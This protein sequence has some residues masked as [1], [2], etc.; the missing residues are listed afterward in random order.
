MYFKRLFKSTIKS[1]FL[2]LHLNIKCFQVNED[3]DINE[4]DTDISVFVFCTYNALEILEIYSMN[5]YVVI[6]GIQLL[7]INNSDISYL[8][9]VFKT[10]YRFLN[11]KS[12]SIILKFQ[13]IWRKTVRME[14]FII[15]L[16]KNFKL[17]KSCIKFFS[18]KLHLIKNRA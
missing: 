9:T 11:D 14:H 18:V 5:Q 1:Y 10:P 13:R 16:C 4:P 15:C 7:T 3:L 6:Y 8:L 2:M 12:F 17:L